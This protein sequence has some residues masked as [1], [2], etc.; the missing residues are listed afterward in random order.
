MEYLPLVVSAYLL[1]LF[2]IVFDRRFGV[3]FWKEL[4]RTSV[5]SI[6]QLLLAGGVIL[7]LVKLKKLEL[8]V[9]S[10]LLFYLNATAISMRRFTFAGYPKKA[11]YVITFLAISIISSFTLLVLYVSGV[12]SLKANSL[13]PLAGI[14]TAAGMRSLSL[15]YKAFHSKLKDLEDV[16]TSMFALGASDF[17]V[18]KYLFVEVLEEITIPVRDMLRSV[19]IVHIPGVMVGLLLSGIMPIKAA[20][21]QFLILSA[22]LFQ[23]TFV[24]AF[25]IFL[26]VSKYGIKLQR[27]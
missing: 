20:F 19:G 1:I 15:G 11:G 6:L 2:V 13:I 23:F 18:V 9:A 4:A 26:L 25:S 3:G 24:P 12:L 27:G 17:G 7:I 5:F 22:M 10:V 21:V 8:C 14:I 16:I